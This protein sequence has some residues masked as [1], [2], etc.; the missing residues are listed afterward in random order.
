MMRNYRSKS[1]LFE[2]KFKHSRNS[3]LINKS[4]SLQFLNLHLPEN[5]GDFTM[6]TS[7]KIDYYCLVRNSCCAR[8]AVLYCL[9]MS[10]RD[11]RLSVYLYAPNIVG[12]FDFNLE[13][14]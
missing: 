11:R 1:I 2:K 10:D 4:V 7:K 8:T 3:A 6:G 14:F 5:L 12:K 13:V 9:N